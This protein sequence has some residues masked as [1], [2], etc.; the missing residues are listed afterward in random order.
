MS[1]VI[2]IQKQDIHSTL[3]TWIYCFMHQLYNAEN[4]GLKAY[5]NW[6]TGKFVKSYEDAKKYSEIP[7]AFEWYFLQPHDTNPTNDKIVWTWEL[8]NWGANVDT[9]DFQ[10]ISEPLS[11]IKDYYKK[12][13]HFNDETNRRGQLLADKYGIDFSKTIGICWRGS[14]IYLESINGYEGRKYTPISYYFEWI[15]KALDDIPDARIACTSEEKEILDPLFKRYGQRAFLIEE[16]YQ[17]P[18]GHKHNPERHSPMSGYLR[19]LQPGLMVWLFSKTAWLIKNRASTSAVA[20]WLSGGNI[21]CI[22]HD[23]RLGF[24]PHLEGVEYKGQV[25]PISK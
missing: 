20:S 1:K 2:Y 9:T 14:D 23:E 3:C 24:P 19:G 10:L 17:V 25:Y 13:L 12:R 11:V 5:I 4:K 21:V 6:P 22:T 7:N 18:K 8:E 16:F 15:D